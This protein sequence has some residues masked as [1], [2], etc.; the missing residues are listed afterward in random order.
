VL[1]Q[2]DNLFKSIVDN[3]DSVKLIL[4]VLHQSLLQKVPMCVFARLGGENGSMI[5]RAAFAVIIKFT[6]MTFDFE[7]LN[8]SIES[9]AANLTTTGVQKLKDIISQLKEQ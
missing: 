9:I 1:E 3:E 7:G 4:E 5:S 8:N 6:D 2:E